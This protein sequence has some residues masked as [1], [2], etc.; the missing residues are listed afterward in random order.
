MTCAASSAW[1]GCGSGR[2]DQCV[3][4]WATLVELEKK[5]SESQKGNSIRVIVGYNEKKECWNNNNENNNN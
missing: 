5:E 3:E 2:G 1:G 4:L